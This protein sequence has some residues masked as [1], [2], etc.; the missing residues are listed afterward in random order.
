MAVKL[1]RYDSVTAIRSM[2][3]QP[4]A[5]SRHANLIRGYVSESYSREDWHG[6]SGGA[7]A[8]MQA[9]LIGHPEGEE[10]IENLLRSLDGKLPQ[11]VGVGRKLVRGMSGDELDI[12]A[13]NR[14]D[15]SRAWSSRQRLI[16]KGKT[17]LK[18]VADVGGNCSSSHDV[19]QW[20]GIAAIALSE[21]MTKAGYSTEIAAA[22]AVRSH[23]RRKSADVSAI[24]CVVKSRGVAADRGLLAA[25]L[26]L[27]G[28]FRTVGFAAIV[29]SADD[30]GEYC[31]E[32]LGYHVD[33]ERVIPPL[34]GVVN[35]FVPASIHDE[36]TATTWI[37]ETVAMLQS[38]K[39]V[40]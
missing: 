36:E 3:D 30:A 25:T 31:D 38:I 19:L 4:C 12:H 37:K 24:E 11:A 21:I 8:V 34:S 22:W 7:V 2:V 28:F 27:S 6:M 15:I 39:G 20:R 17:A 18:I 26:A 33:V 14:G 35:L 32:G 29:R 9:M 16:K 5:M 10:K 23:I 1:T 40:N 13:V